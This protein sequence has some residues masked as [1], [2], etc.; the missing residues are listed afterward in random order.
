MFSAFLLSEIKGVMLFVAKNL[1]L[2]LL[3]ILMLVQLNAK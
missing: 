1:S 2:L 3:F